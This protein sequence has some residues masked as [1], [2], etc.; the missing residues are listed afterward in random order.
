[1]THYTIHVYLT[2]KTQ[3]FRFITSCHH[4]L[5]KN[6]NDEKSQGINRFLFIL[7]SVFQIISKLTVRQNKFNSHTPIKFINTEFD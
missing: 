4:T 7:K 3:I 1:M 2:D 6:L 5:F